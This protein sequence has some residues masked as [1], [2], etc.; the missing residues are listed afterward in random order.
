MSVLVKNWREVQPKIAHLSA[1]HWGGLRRAEIAHDP[2]D[3]NCL[4]HLDGFARHALQGRKTSD[5]HRHENLEQVYYVLGGGGEVLYGEQRYPVREGDAI[6]LPSGVYHQMFNDENEA[7]LEHHVISMKVEGDG[8]Q[9]LVRNWRQ[10]APVSDGEGGVR[11][12]Q[13]GRVGEAGIGCL[14]GM[15]GIECEAVVPGGQTRECRLAEVE[16]VYYILENRGTLVVE[17]QEYPV[18]EGDMIHLPPGTRYQF[19]NAHAAWLRSLIM[20]A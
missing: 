11:W 16:Q 7:W 20:A 5:H 9:F 14:R 18:S 4:H 8:G 17:G 3:R 1:V 15:A 2:D 12:R 13:L 10:V 6:Y 19:R